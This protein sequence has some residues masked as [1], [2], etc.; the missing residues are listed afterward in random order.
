MLAVVCPS[1][2]A[3]LLAADPCPV[4]VADANFLKVIYGGHLLLVRPCV[5]AFHG[6]NNTFLIAHVLVRVRAGGIPFS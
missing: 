3:A 2:T 1:T 6:G 4:I 5:L